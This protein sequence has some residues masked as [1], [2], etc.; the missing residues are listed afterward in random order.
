MN[1]SGELVSNLTGEAA[2]LSFKPSP[3]PPCPNIVMDDDML[4]KLTEAKSELSKLEAA[5]EL[6]PNID[7]FISMYVRKEALISSQRKAI[8]GILIPTK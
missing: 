4:H 8:F 2:Y 5:A 6:I 3:L 1:R 7:L